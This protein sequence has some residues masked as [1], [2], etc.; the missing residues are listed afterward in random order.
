MKKGVY[1]LSLVIVMTFGCLN[2]TAQDTLSVAARLKAKVDSL[3]NSHVSTAVAEIPA[4]PTDTLDLQL[5]PV[6]VIPVDSTAIEAGRFSAEELYRMADSMR[7]SYNFPAAAELFRNAAATAVDSSRIRAMEDA[8]IMS[9]NGVELMKRCSQPSVVAKERFAIE[10]FFLYYPM[11]NRSWHSVPNQLD[12][13]GDHPLVKATYVPQNQSE[14]FFSASGED[15]IRHLFS[16][17]DRDT[18]WTAPAPVFA[19][20]TCSYDVIYP[21]AEPDGKTL[22]FASRGRCSIGGYDL[23]VSKWDEDAKAWGTPANM[24]FPYSSPY[25]D[26]LYVNTPDGKYS[27]FASNRE[28]S[29]DSVYIYVLE[30]NAAPARRHVSS[31]SVLKNLSRL[32][33]N[34]DNLRITQSSMAYAVSENDGTRNYMT[35]MSRVRA[36]RDTISS[37]NSILETKRAGL[38]L[39]EE[40]QKAGMTEE[41][42]AQEAAILEW[43]KEL[44]TASKALRS[45]EMEFLANGVIL[46]SGTA[47]NPSGRD[48]VGTSNGYT[49]TRN[50]PGGTLL[51]KF[52]EKN[53]QLTD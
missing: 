21:V 16:I 22:Y 9:Q 27:I 2:A 28:T 8:M 52:P 53:N 20:S 24:G 18:S 37:A 50:T 38:A 45:I 36:L 12:P 51:F 7:L 25:D 6:P 44:D 48:V 34:V 47:Q 32:T 43:Q 29:R 35:A 39:A 46:D 11:E 19:D 3:R 10:D 23:F 26:F 49:F 4:P 1:I 17:Q 15:G 42:K 40:E 31:V 5:E 30:Y 41:V 14:L 33:P 13:G